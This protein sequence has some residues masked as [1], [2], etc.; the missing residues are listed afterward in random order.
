MRLLYNIAIYLLVAGL[1][2]L[3]LFNA[4]VR[5][6]VRG[7]RKQRMEVR[8]WKE[9]CAQDD[10]GVM[11]HWS[12]LG[13]FEQGRTLNASLREKYPTAKLVLTFFSPSGYNA[14]KNFEVV[15][16]VFYL[17]FDTPSGVRRFVSD[18]APSRVF[19]IKYEYWYNMLR[20]LNRAG[21]KVYI[22][23]AIFRQKSAFFSSYAPVRTFYRSMLSFFTLIF[24]QNDYS[25]E[26]LAQMGY[27]DRVKVVGDTRFDRVQQ[28]CE[29]AQVNTLVGEFASAGQPL[30]VCGSTWG[31]DEQLLLEVMH[32]RPQWRFVVAPH[33]INHTHIQ[34]FIEASSRSAALYSEGVVSADNTL[35]VVDTIGVL[36][37]LYRYATV[38]Y[39]GGGFGAGIHNTLE[40]AT[41]GSPVVFGPKYEKFREARELIACGG[42]FS[43]GTLDELQGVLDSFRVAGRAG[44]A[45][46][47]AYVESEVGATLRI[48]GYL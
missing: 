44:G 6:M 20:Q 40:A 25:A 18:L 9:S 2:V 14:C 12:S 15:D 47:R 42:A 43:I 3:Q 23:S 26:L 8:E 46:A 31:G 4:K 30:I 16:K 32:S 41:W 45:R 28:L 10:E 37:S 13:E 38:S 35:L 7:R 22:V 24:V 17:P 48:V 36:R 27:G 33:E 29:Q 34:R 19:I 39:I 1:W 11:V 5:A 21:S